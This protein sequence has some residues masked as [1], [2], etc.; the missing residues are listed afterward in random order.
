M[1]DLVA[2]SH[3]S[4][5]TLS[6]LVSGEVSDEEIRRLGL[7]L[8]SCGSCRCRVMDSVERPLP[9]ALDAIKEAVRLADYE[10]EQILGVLTARAEWEALRRLPKAAQRDR[11]VLSRACHTREYLALLLG[12]VTGP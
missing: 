4:A 5:G 12:I 7:H 9:R 8:Q 11:L 1:Y 3:L 6:R 10:T 2:E